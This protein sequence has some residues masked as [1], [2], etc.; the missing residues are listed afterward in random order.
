MADRHD[1]TDDAQDRSSNITDADSLRSVLLHQP[2]RVPPLGAG[3]EHRGIAR[4]TIRLPGPGNPDCGRSREPAQAEITRSPRSGPF[5]VS[6][7]GP[8]AKLR[9]RSV[10]MPFVG[11]GGKGDR[12]RAISHTPRVRDGRSMKV[13]PGIAG[14]R[15][16]ARWRINSSMIL[17][18][19]DPAGRATASPGVSTW[20]CRPTR[21][22]RRC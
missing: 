16:E 6:T 11:P 14:R 18:C 12:E 5:L 9:R 20:R 13:C 22:E 1:N 8:Q 19:V 15:R 21:P 4:E 17:T 10:I 7:G 3:K 2:C